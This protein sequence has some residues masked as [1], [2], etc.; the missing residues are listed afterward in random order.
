[1]SIQNLII[2]NFTSLF[3]ILEELGSDLN[4]KIIFADSDKS[5]N[6]KIKILIII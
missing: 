1:M 2:Y 6:D 4:F 3:Q 5:L